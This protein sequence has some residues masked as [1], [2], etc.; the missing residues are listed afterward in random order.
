MTF[1]GEPIA[2]WISIGA[3]LI[4]LSAILMTRRKHHKEDRALL[5]KQIADIKREYGD[6][7]LVIERILNLI[8]EVLP[9]S[10]AYKKLLKLKSEIEEFYKK[11]GH[12][13][14][15][16]TDPVILSSVAIESKQI[17]DRL[18]QLLT[19]VNRLLDKYQRGK[20]K[21]SRKKNLLPRANQRIKLTQ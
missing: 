1:L 5:A 16:T 13:D 12:Q 10:T 17:K 15:I 3:F 20:I 8:K 18:E 2:T 9:K 19:E 14:P 7:L 21:G 4:S 6:G 11:L